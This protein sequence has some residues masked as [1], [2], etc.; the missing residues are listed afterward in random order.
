MSDATP[1]AGNPP[2]A[3]E[4]FFWCAHCSHVISSV[5][6][7]ADPAE[8]FKCPRCHKWTVK[9]QIPM[10]PRARRPAMQPTASPAVPAHSEQAHDLFSALKNVVA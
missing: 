4:G 3:A 7:D 5:P 9:W 2:A 6:D 8:T 1:E 10:K